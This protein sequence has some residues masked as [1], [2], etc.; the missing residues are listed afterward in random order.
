MHP[1][2]ILV[3]TLFLFG[4]QTTQNQSESSE[5]LMK[6]EKPAIEKDLEAEQKLKEEEFLNEISGIW[7]ESVLG[8]KVT[9]DLRGTNKKYDLGYGVYKLTVKSINLKSKTVCFNAL[10]NEDT[11]PHQMCIRMV[12]L[13]FGEYFLIVDDEYYTAP[14]E[15]YYIR[16]LD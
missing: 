13:G 3:I 6:D 7:Q 4:C 14:W 16:A 11:K 12:D 5:E 9:L 15:M 2:S 10:Y 8:R 1:I